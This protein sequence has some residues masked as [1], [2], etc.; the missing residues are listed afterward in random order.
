MSVARISDEATTAVQHPRREDRRSSRLGRQVLSVALLASMI[1]GVGGLAPRLGVE[2]SDGEQITAFDTGMGLVGGLGLTPASLTTTTLT[3]EAIP[4]YVDVSVGRPVTFTTSDGK[5][6]QVK[7]V[8]QSRSKATVGVLTDGREQQYSFTLDVARSGGSPA[9]QPPVNVNGVLVLPEVVGAVQEV[10][11]A[12]RRWSMLR[13]SWETGDQSVDQGQSDTNDNAARLFVADPARPLPAGELPYRVNRDVSDPRFQSSPFLWLQSY[14]IHIG[15][16]LG[17]EASTP[18]HAVRGG[19]IIGVATNDPTV[20]NMVVLDDGAFVYR[21]MH[22]SSTAVTYGQR[23]AQG[24]Y[25][26]NSGQ[27]GLASVP[28]LHLD[29]KSKALGIYVNPFPYLNAWRG[30]ATA[31]A[32]T[33]TPTP[34]PSPTPVPTGEALQEAYPDRAE[35]AVGYKLGEW[36][37]SLFR[38]RDGLVLSQVGFTGGAGAY[39]ELRRSDSYG[40]W[41]DVLAWGRLDT[42]STNGYYTAA[43]TPTTLAPGHYTFH[44]YVSQGPYEFGTVAKTHPELEFLKS[45][46]GTTRVAVS[47]GTY[48]IRFGFTP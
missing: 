35:T 44:V 39:W 1:G 29:V 40:N 24:A 19:T 10:D 16:D 31:T 15:S 26:G 27:T 33:S 8:S 43:V 3:S 18:L 22:M 46:P 25:L 30:G 34:A 42:T 2:A 21:Y 37:N 47:E 4:S 7:L 12:Y 6:H 17:L 38:V 28:H 9:L 13:V 14:G 23:V 36:K 48:R 5:A 45:S 11:A 20:G 32:P 41:Y